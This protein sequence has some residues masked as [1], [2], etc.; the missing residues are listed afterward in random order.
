MSNV[1][2]KQKA[3]KMGVI[4][5]FAAVYII[6]GSTYLAIRYALETLPP[7]LMAGA[8]HTLAGAVLYGVLRAA[9]T[10]RPQRIH[11]RSAAIIG[12]LLLL[13]GNGGVCWAEQTVPSG[14]AALLVTTVPIWMVLLNWF[15]REGV[16][17]GT[18]EIGGVALGLLGVIIL[19]GSENLGGAPVHRMG[20]V[21]LMAASL[22]WAIGS[23]YSRHAP[24][25]QSPLMV[26]AMQMLC[27]GVL[28]LL[29]GAASG[30]GAKLELENVS[31][32]SLISLG[33]LTVFG[34]LVAFSAY[35]WLLRVSTPAKVSTYA[36][37]NPV[38]AVA[39]GFVFAGEPLTPRT[40]GAAAVIV[41]A[42]VLITRQRRR[43]APATP[44]L[45]EPCDRQTSRPRRE[46]PGVS[47]VESRVKIVGQ[48]LD[49]DFAVGRCERQIAASV[50]VE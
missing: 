14:L 41:T 42:V 24:L 12:A 10:A 44:A 21:V 45:S 9:G 3:S 19:I 31:L 46:G 20:A 4:A 49:S 26:T 27:G 5:A 15:R 39:L 34:S 32:R 29:S 18:M 35:V 1:G 6:W 50:C 17:P 2:V 38:V 11:W 8:R 25:P 16:R 48:E 40:M 7:L 47:T 22:S 43:T 23:I 37:V 36:F 13:I 30:E 28:L 33:Y